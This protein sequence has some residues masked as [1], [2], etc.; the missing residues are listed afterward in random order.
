MNLL[1][2]D[3]LQAF[4]EELQRHMFPHVLEYLAK[5]KGFVQQIITA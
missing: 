3:E 4:A 1:I 2:F 5:E